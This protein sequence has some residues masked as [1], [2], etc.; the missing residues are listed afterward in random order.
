MRMSER[1]KVDIVIDTNVL[2]Y[3]DN[4]QVA[5]E[6]TCLALLEWLADSNL[7]WVLDDNGKSAPDPMTSVLYAEYTSTLSPQGYALTLFTHFLITGRCSFVRRPDQATAQKIRRLVPKN[8]R[9]RTILGAAVGSYDRILVSSDY[10]D[11][12]DAV[13]YEAAR[14]LNVDI[15]DPGE[16]AVA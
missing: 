5:F 10:A 3:A 8:A 4:F 16:C 1:C 14:H 6:P 12:P 13:R 15:M 7:A 11:F 9:D 2:S